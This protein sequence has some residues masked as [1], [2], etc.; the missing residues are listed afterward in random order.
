MADLEK[1]S[2]GSL[3]LLA[4]AKINLCLHVTGKRD[5]G[6]HLLESLIVFADIGDDL[7]VHTSDSIGLELRG[8]QA[9]ILGSDQTE[10]LI[11]RAAR[12]LHPF[13][14]Q[15][16]GARFVL[17]KNLPVASGIGGGSSD[18][19]SAIRLLESAWDLQIE[20]DQRSELLVTLGA[21][22]PVCYLG[23]SAVARGIGEILTPVD[24]LP[25][26]YVVLANPGVAVATGAIFK[27]LSSF[28]KPVSEKFAHESH[29][30]GHFVELLGGAFNTLERPALEVEP[31]I[32]TVLDA[33][34]ATAGCALAR[35]SGSGATCF[36]LF[37]DPHMA[38]VASEQLRI[39]HPDWWISH[40]RILTEAPH[41]ERFSAGRGPDE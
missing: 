3:R 22:V 32:S 11:I 9:G 23:L 31:T 36:G 40:G 29:S 26:M 8:P 10:N 4:P 1:V 12:M 15:Q 33:L 19:A 28:D 34:R 18:A 37:E 14:K 16:H 21:D 5:D 20:E 35:M 13:A 24:H 38:R 27:R 7:E 30:F 39:T 25:E 41:V 17:T 6:Y 2:R